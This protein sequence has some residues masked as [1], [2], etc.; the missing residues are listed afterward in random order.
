[1]ASESDSGSTAP[2]RLVGSISMQHSGCGWQWQYL[3]MVDDVWTIRAWEKIQSVL[4]ENN[5][6]SR[7]IVTTRIET[8]AKA[9]SP[10][11][12]GHYIHQMQP[13][14]FEDSKKLFISR[15]FVNKNCP[16]ELED[17]TNNIL[18]R[19]G[20][21]PLAIVSIAS[22]L[23]GYTSA[24]SKDKWESIYK[25]IGSEMESNPTLEGMRQIVTLS[26]N[27]LS[28]E[29]KSCMMYFSIFPEDYEVHKDRLLWR[30]IAEG[31]V[32]EKRGLSLMEV[33]ESYM[34]ELVNRNMIQLRVDFEYY[35][36][37]QLYRVH[38]MFLEVMVSKSL[39]SNFVSLLGGQYATM[40]YDRIRRLSI[41][42]DDDRLE[43]DAGL[44]E[45]RKNNV[46]ASSGID[47]ISDFGHIR[48]LSM[49]QHSG[50]KL[51]DQL[52]KFTLLRVLDLE[53]FRGLTMAH[54]RY[55]CRL[56]LLRF[57]SLKGTDVSEIP[58]QIE[59]L[60]HLQTLDVRRTSIPGLPETVKRL[61]GLERL[62]ISYSGEANHMW[63]LPLGLK[64][65]K[66][67]REVGF[68]V[69][70]NDVQV[71]RDVGELEHLQELVVYVDDIVFDEE[72]L[73]EFAKS[74]S[75]AYSLR[76]LIVGDVGYGKTLNFLDRLHAPPRLLRYLM[77]AGGIDRLPSWIK[78]LT[79][80]VQFN[81]SWGKVV[82]DQLFDVLCELPSLKTISIHNYCY[83]GND[84]VARARHR[85]PELINLRIASGSQFP[86]VV[87]FEKGSMG[88]LEALLV[89]FSDNDAKRMVGIQHLTCL[90]E[91]QLWGN[92]NNPALTGALKQ[93]KSLNKR[94]LAESNNQFQIVVR[95]D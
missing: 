73:D 55:I 17:V 4:L 90:K 75:K 59:K 13:L 50:Q 40:S 67:L 78:S 82:G 5:R 58:P 38:D 84:L 25:S 21:L 95:Y 47:G 12:G 36:M 18:K 9:C 14:K 35:W 94:R 3:I 56:Y 85:F 92:K 20:G 24:G 64:K 86:N 19:C 30:W 15:T 83:A 91:V 22:V 53:S 27:H 65:M 43:I 6:S 32:Q 72:V 74:L 76:R 23:A 62:Q 79:Y 89:N 68:S 26:Y 37:A 48:S 46:T 33:A 41:Q 54:M 93:L 87:R 51:L 60:E 80:L 31:L 49:F 61:Y 8:V 71:A 52:G 81:M 34:D 1:M 7:I 44:Q 2:R 11:I 45:A 29:L 88:K 70:G 39:E 10:T 57:L 63:R 66:A 69:L 42:G 28:H 77:I 16:Q